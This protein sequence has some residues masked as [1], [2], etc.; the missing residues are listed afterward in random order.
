MGLTMRERQAVTRELT[1][2]FRKATKKERG[3]MLDEFVH[4]T[5][6]NRVYAAY[7]LRSCGRPEVRLVHGRRVVFVPGHGRAPGAARKKEPSPGVSVP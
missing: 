1:T 6:Y 4:L 2:R 3:R 7:V 5:G